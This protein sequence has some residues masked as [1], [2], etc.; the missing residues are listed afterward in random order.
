MKPLPMRP[1]RSFGLV[2]SGI[3]VHDEAAVEV[4]REDIE[5]VLRRT[6]LSSIAATRSLDGMIA[7][8]ALAIIV[9]NKSRCQ[10][11]MR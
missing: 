4:T 10:Y 1:M 8:D 9:A 11:S 7:T 6:H 3:L 5:H 2:M